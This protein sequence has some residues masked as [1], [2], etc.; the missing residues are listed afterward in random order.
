VELPAGCGKTQLIAELVN[1]TVA[2]GQRTLILTHTHAGVDALRR[3]L[4]Q[5]GVPAHGYRV[6]TLDSWCFELISHFQVLAG[7]YVDP[8]PQWTRSRD[9]HEAG[10][11]AI[12]SAAVVRMLKVSYD[13]LIVDEY[14]DCQKWQHDLV[15]AVSETLPTCVLGDRMQ[16]L[17]FFGR[18]DPVSW[19]H[20][21]TPAFPPVEVPIVAWRWAEQNPAL[22]AWLLE[23]RKT[24]LAGDAVDLSSM[25]GKL[26]ASG[27]ITSACYAQPPHPER[28]VTIGPMPYDCAQLA[29]RLGGTYTVLEELEGKHLLDYARLFDAGDPAQL[30]V[31][32]IKFAISCATGPAKAFSTKERRTLESGKPLSGKLRGREAQAEALNAVLQAGT[33]DAVRGAL[34]TMGKL[35]DFKLH[36]R[37]AWYGVLSALRLAAL[38]D[39]LSVEQAVVKERSQLRNGG[40]RP[41]SRIVARPLLIKGLEFDHAVVDQAAKYNSHELYVALT[42]GSQSVTVASDKSQLHPRRPG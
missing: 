39:G 4:R 23:V 35:P 22:G 15:R 11:R 20:D 1:E 17:F 42:R 14:Q 7:T 6:S 26:V 10:A 8:E 16:G 31:G 36:R 40:R 24:L 37:E 28:V 5:L 2:A 29:L 12:R 21:V 38:T 27:S 34:V 32:S 25:P 33:V 41:S 19:E 18:N 9:Y 13:M 30:A 3:R